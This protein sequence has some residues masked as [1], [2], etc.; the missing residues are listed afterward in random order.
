MFLT[1]IFSQHCVNCILNVPK[2]FWREFFSLRA[3]GM[4]YQFQFFGNKSWALFPKNFWPS[5][6][7]S[8]R[9]DQSSTSRRNN[10]LTE[11]FFFLRLEFLGYG[12]KL[13]RFLSKKRIGGV[14]LL[15][16]LCVKSRILKK[17][18]S[19]KTVINF[20]IFFRRRTKTLWVFPEYL[21]WKFK[22]GFC[23]TRSTFSWKIV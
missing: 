14:I 23:L 9:S 4:I 16:F 6:Q 17:D 11:M 7:N 12:R 2:N 13:F 8:I 15:W 10:F 3:P 18:G 5:F 21:S 20:A 19:F 1:S 22:A